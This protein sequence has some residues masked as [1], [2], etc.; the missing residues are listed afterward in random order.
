METLVTDIQGPAR[1]GKDPILKH[2]GEDNKSVCEMRVIFLNYRGNKQVQDNPIDSG[3]WAQVNIWGKFA[4]P[5]SR[6]FSTG[7]KIYI[8]G[9][10]DQ[11]SF[12]PKGANEDDDEV[13]ILQM[14]SNL[15]FPW[16]A[17][18][19]SLIFTER[20]VLKNTSNSNNG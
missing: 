11:D 9:N 16:T 5:A 1:L 20:K 14:N 19:E 3:F 18:I 10:M 13:T 12:K 8:S 4:E 2:V 6:L 15:I 17:D 7:D